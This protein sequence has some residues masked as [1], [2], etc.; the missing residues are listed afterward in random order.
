MPKSKASADGDDHMHEFQLL[1]KDVQDNQ[2]EISA[3]R[4][5][6]SSVS[7]KQDI[8]HRAVDGMQNTVS[9]IRS[10]MTAMAETL[11]TLHINPMGKQPDASQWEHTL[12]DRLPL[13]S[14][15]AADQAALLQKRLDVDA[16]RRQ[17]VIEQEVSRRYQQNIPVTHRSAPPGFGQASVSNLHAHIDDSDRDL[18]LPL[19]PDDPQV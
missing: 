1:K 14:S 19:E 12:D 7:A 8:L 13:S 10:L 18:H 2:H 17:V 16:L 6:L 9:D 3:T 5:D 4:A 15:M 11:K